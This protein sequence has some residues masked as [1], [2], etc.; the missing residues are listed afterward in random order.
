MQ[1]TGS[2][3]LSQ[4]DLFQQETLT[5]EAL[6][7]SA[8]AISVDT[9]NAISSLAL[10]D[11]SKPSPSPAG[12]GTGLCGPEAAHA[13]HSPLLAIVAGS[14][15]IATFGRNGF[16]S[17]ASVA[18]QS[19]L[20]SKLRVR[21]NGSA[22]C[23]VTWKPWATPWGQCLSKPRARIRTSSEIAFGLWPTM[24]SNAPAKNGYNEAGNSA[25]QVAIRKI[26]LGLWPAVTVACA[27][28]GQKS[29]SGARKGELLLTGLVAATSKLLN[30]PTENGGQS[31][32]PEFAG[33]EMGYR[34]A[35]LNCAPSETP[36]T[37][38]RR[39]NSSEHT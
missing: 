26:L 24:T 7:K 10:A 17:S 18:L 8:P 22:L 4:Q 39:Q 27:S 28:G 12:L 34:P 37:R 16:G 13:S 14:P 23:E 15:T 29:R 2:E 9:R 30:V 31:L 36:S 3:I 32:H 19:S 35:W 20:E 38:G 5:T 25:G 6:P 33:W 11:G 1:R 21:L